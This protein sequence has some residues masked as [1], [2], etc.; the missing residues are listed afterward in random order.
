MFF[1]KQVLQR[2]GTVGFSSRN[3]GAA[4]LEIGA[5]GLLGLHHKRL[6]KNE[7]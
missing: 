7:Q 1:Q 5:G 2:R 4:D 3:G 6:V